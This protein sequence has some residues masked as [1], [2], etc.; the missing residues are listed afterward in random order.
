MPSFERVDYSIRTNKNIERKLVFDKLRTMDSVFHF[1][2]YRYMGLGSMWFVDFIMAHR[3]LGIGD[4]WSLEESNAERA[5]FNKPYACIRVLAGTS[6]ATLE[7]LPAADW[8]KPTIVWFDYDGAF[9]EDVRSDAVKLLERVSAGSVLIVT[10][11]ADR[12]SYRPP[13][14]ADQAARA[15]DRLTELFGDAVPPQIIPE[16]T[17]DIGAVEFPG[18]LSSVILNLM[19]GSVR[20]SGRSTD[21]MP[22]RF[23]PLFELQHRDGAQMTTCGGI[24]VSGRQIEPLEQLLRRP[25]AELF[26]GGA[27]IRENIDLIPLTVREKIALDRVL[28]CADDAEFLERFTASAVMV[29]SAE[30]NKYRRWYRHFPVFAEVG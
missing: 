17:A 25:A 15:I 3:I 19:I 12:R 16:G 9:D 20:T 1:S 27:A 28:P 4:L 7:G 23:V 26:A 13:G 30:A 18:T 2:S 21:G 8:Q 10:V 29:D 14:P 6:T 24:V 22:D 11:N 5:E